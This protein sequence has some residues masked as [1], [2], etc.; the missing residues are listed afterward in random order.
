M[1]GPVQPHGPAPLSQGR[2][3]GSSHSPSLFLSLCP[4]VQP[5]PTVRAPV[6]IVIVLFT[7]LVCC[8]PRVLV[9]P[10]SFLALCSQEAGISVP[11]VRS[12]SLS[13]LNRSDLWQS[14]QK[15][16]QG[17]K[18]MHRF[19]CSCENKWN[20]TGLGMLCLNKRCRMIV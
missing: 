5:G 8:P 13:F 12:S 11:P 14:L 7:A 6:R 15:K 3:A 19:F 9:F 10:R 1:G 17:H 18:E 4:R 16:N 20:K 2:R